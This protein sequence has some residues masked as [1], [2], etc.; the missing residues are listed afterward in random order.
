M[1]KKQITVSKDQLAQQALNILRQKKR[2]EVP[3]AN[4][5]KEPVVM[6]DVQD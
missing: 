6:L 5:K 4:K 1:S 2:D 3:V